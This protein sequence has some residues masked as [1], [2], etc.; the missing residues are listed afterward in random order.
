MKLINQNMTMKKIKTG[1][2]VVHE[3]Q[4][5]EKQY[6]NDNENIRKAQKN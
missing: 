4:G 5:V 2:D 6:K 1:R 3:S